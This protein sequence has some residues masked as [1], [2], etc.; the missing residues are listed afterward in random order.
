MQYALDSAENL[1]RNCIQHF[2]HHN[3]YDL[4]KTEARPQIKCENQAKKSW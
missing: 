3:Y 2:Y 4:H 1:G